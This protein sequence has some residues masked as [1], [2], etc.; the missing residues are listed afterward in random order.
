MHVLLLLTTMLGVLLVLVSS[1]AFGRIMADLEYQYAAGL[2]GV[3][4]IQSWVNLRTHGNRV[5]L[6]LLALTTGVLAFTDVPDFWRVW[7][8]RALFVG[9]LI[10]YTVSSILDWR[11]ERRQVRMLLREREA[12]HGH[13]PIVPGAVR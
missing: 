1:A 10:S 12:E 13:G 2:N 3:R 7:V 8:T 9:V 4:R 5:F 6:G 11:D